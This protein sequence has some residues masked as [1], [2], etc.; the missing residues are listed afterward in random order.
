VLLNHQQYNAGKGVPLIVIHGLF[1]A[2][3]NWRSHILRWS[4][5][6]HIV[7]LDLRNHGRSGHADDMSYHAMAADVVALMNS[8]NIKHAHILGHSM[9]GKVATQMALDHP[10]LVSSLILADIAPVPYGPRHGDVLAGLNAVDTSTLQSRKQGLEILAAYI[11]DIKVCQFL[12]KSL[13]RNTA[14]EF[15]WRFNLAAIEKQYQNISAAPQGSS[16]T[17]PVLVIKGEESAYIQPEHR[18]AFAKFLPKAQ[19]KVMTGCG[20]WLHAEKPDLFVRLVS[21]FLQALA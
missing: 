10:R 19:L 17:G 4:E 3:D 21:R 15:A 12:I 14:G 9:G 11:D 1:G 2:A 5:E 16:Y 20:H 18:A 6:R 8:L 7:S 13:Y